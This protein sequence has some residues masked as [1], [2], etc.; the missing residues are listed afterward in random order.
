MQVSDI[1]VSPVVVT[2]KNKTVKHV[3]G[4]I[5][6]KSINAIPVLTIDGEID[7]I[8]TSNDIAREANDEQLVES[9]MTTKTYVV[10]VNSGVQDAAKMMDKHHVHHLVVMDEGQ[11]VGILS[12][13]DFVKI[14]AQ[15]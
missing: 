4:L 14:V 2:Q 8:I 1:M 15:G 12:S 13:M 9:I 5:E 7:G 10:G 11:V 6:R 3:R